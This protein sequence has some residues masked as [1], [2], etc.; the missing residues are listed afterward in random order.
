MHG[1]HV[2]SDYHCHCSEA[3]EGNFMDR[4]SASPSTSYASPSIKLTSLVFC[5]DVGN[6]Q[7]ITR[8]WLTQQTRV[9]YIRRMILAG[10]TL[11][12]GRK[13]CLSFCAPQTLDGLPWNRNRQP[14]M[15]TQG[16]P[17]GI[18]YRLTSQ[19]VHQ[20]TYALN[21]IHSVRVSVWQ[22]IPPDTTH[23]ICSI[24]TRSLRIT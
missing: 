6:C 9:R 19:S 22:I 20:P 2:R 21:K 24:T 5:N 4:P 18:L 8:R 12:T 7:V 14:A 13:T 16:S 3:T 15:G 11:S 10:E 1:K 23:F 17:W